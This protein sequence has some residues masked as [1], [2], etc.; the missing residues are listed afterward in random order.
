MRYQW[1]YCSLAL[2]LE[3]LQSCTYHVIKASHCICKRHPIAWLF[4]WN[5][6]CHLWVLILLFN[7][8]WPN[9][10]IWQH[11]FAS[12]GSNSSL[13]PGGIWPNVDVSLLSFWGIHLRAII[14]WVPKLLF[15]VMSSN[16][17]KIDATSP[18]GQWVNSVQGM[19]TDTVK[20]HY[21]MG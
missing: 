9:D 19:Y 11:K 4:D 21:D 12:N 5:M 13:L 6:K 20:P 15:C 3:L 1:S 16:A 2:D 8:L 14:Q 17:F 18:W 7:S 10:S